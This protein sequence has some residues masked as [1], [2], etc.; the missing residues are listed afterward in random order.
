MLHLILK[1]FPQFSVEYYLFHSEWHFHKLLKLEPNLIKS[2]RLSLFSRCGAALSF[3]SGQSKL[4]NQKRKPRMSWPVVKT[5]SLLV[6]IISSSLL[7]LLASAKEYRQHEEN[8]EIRP[9]P[10]AAL[11]GASTA[12][13][14]STMNESKRQVMAASQSREFLTAHNLVRLHLREPPLKWDRRLTRYARRFASQ[15]IV[16]CKMVHSFG[17]YGENI[18]WGGKDHWTPRDIVRSW[19]REHRYYHLRTNECDPG[20]MCGHYTQV[21]WRESARVGC[22][23]VTCNNGGM[24]AICSYD[25]PGN[26]INESPF[27]IAPTDKDNPKVDPTPPTSL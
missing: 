9:P 21:I 6:L 5:R 26:Y 4:E 10:P 15:R 16:D 14:N 2:L 7:V 18:F 3:G 19:I 23:K 1:M 27:G 8:F 12:S 11:D 25:P 17:P 24:Y 13:I 20:Q 22:A